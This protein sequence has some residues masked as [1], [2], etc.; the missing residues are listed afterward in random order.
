M[1]EWQS[2]LGVFAILLW[3]N[4][5]LSGAFGCGLNDTTI[6]LPDHYKIIFEGDRGGWI[7][8][9]DGDQIEELNV[10]DLNWQ[11]WYIYGR[12]WQS[13]THGEKYNWFI[14]D[15]S[16]RSVE[17]FASRDQWERQLNRHYIFNTTLKSHNDLRHEK[18]M[19]NTI[20]V[21]LISLWIGACAVWFR[22]HRRARQ[23]RPNRL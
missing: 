2:P 21:L 11:D 14:L 22:Q 18:T 9:S 17:G 4:I 8:D 20:I 12:S 19:F 5:L 3:A 6:S 7:L 13:L 23:D 15:T 10:I 1:Q 16:T